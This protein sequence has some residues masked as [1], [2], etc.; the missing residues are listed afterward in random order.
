L[1]YREITA[2]LVREPFNLRLWEIE[3]LN[4]SQILSIYF[5]PR[6]D[7]GR[8]IVKPKG[9]RG[10]TKVEIFRQHYFSLGYSTEEVDALVEKCRQDAIREA[11]NRLKQP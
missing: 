5:Y 3:K 11:E 6:D 2:I 10:R 7:Q 4:L 8:M 1:S 9:S